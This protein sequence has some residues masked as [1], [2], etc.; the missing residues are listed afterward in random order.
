MSKLE[1]ASPRDISDALIERLQCPLCGGRERQTHLGFR[2]IPVVRCSRC[3]FLFSS[4]ILSDAATR[5]YYQGNF[6]SQRHLDGQRVNARTNAVVLERLLDLSKVKSWLDIGCGYGFLLRWLVKHGIV[7]EG[8]ELST[9]EA[10]YARAAGLSVHNSLLS[11]AGLPIDHFDVVSSFEV[12]E[13]IADPRALLAEMAHYVRPGGFL[14][15]MT[16]N[17]E[18]A[19][20]RKLRGA[21]PKWIPHSHVSH[22]GPESLRACIKGIRGLT[23]EQEAGYTPWDVSGRHLL[24]HVSPA[25]RDEEAFDLRATLS[26]EMNKHYKLFHL[27]YY[28]NPVWTRLTLGRKME[29]GAL[30]YALCRKQPA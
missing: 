30:M 20:A 26:T 24:A 2:D 25:V 8:V 10:N 14:V 5:D 29:S 19:A 7:A 1:T 23:I 15:V 11:E 28:S 3:G 27:R 9:Q 21:F 13:H 6:G 17:F 4:R 16:D 22:F 18:S 12:I